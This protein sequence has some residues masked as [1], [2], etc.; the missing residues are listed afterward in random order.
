MYIVDKRISIE[1]FIAERDEPLAGVAVVRPPLCRL[2]RRQRAVRVVAMSKGTMMNPPA[3]F[4][5][6]TALAKRIRVG[7]N[8]DRPVSAWRETK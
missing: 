7:H 2:R 3:S 8:A 4:C 6:A 1:K 5:A